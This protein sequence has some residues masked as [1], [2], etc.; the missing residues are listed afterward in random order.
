[1]KIQKIL[2]CL[3]LVTLTA[4]SSGG[5]MGSGM[6]GMKAHKPN[7]NST[8]EIAKRD[9]LFRIVTIK[10]DNAAMDKVLNNDLMNCNS[11]TFSMPRGNTVSS[12]IREIFEN[13]L[14]TA[15]KY[16]L[17]GS[18]INVVVKSLL[19]DT[20]KIERGTWTII[21]DY[22]EDGKTTNVETVTT[23]ESKFGLL[24]ACVNTANIFEE[25]VADN[26]VEY[27]RR[28]SR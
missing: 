14:S 3:T 20:S 4:C 9:G 21:I 8:L 19:P 5:G 2:L 17:N 27:F 28:A 13:E 10:G 24:S 26:F 15:K 23:F 6:G 25:A 12:F 7:L 11:T 16:S 18:G 1:M 22:I